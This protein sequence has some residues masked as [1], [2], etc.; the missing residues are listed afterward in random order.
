MEI[1]E[2]HRTPDGLLRFVVERGPDGDLALGFDGYSWHMHGDIL[3][4]LSGLPVEEAV[5]AFIDGLL[6]GESFIGISRVRGEIQDAWVTDD[7]RPDK[8]KPDEETM[9]FRYWDGR[10]AI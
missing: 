2:E 10:P 7:P 3:A 9:E 8:Y 4:S 6:K 1:I 5:R